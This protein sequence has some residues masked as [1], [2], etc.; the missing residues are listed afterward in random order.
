MA[1][2]Q[3][4]RLHLHGQLESVRAAPN[5]FLFIGVK[6][7]Q[8][9]KSCPHSRGG[10]AHQGA[11]GILGDVLGFCLPCRYQYPHVPYI[12]HFLSKVMGIGSGPMQ[13]KKKKAISCQCNERSMYKVEKNGLL[14]I[15][16][17]DEEG[18]FMGSFKK[19]YLN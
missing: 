15:N 11:G 4:S 17:K 18:T 5:L 2:P 10:Y 8:T 6:S 9:H 19:R 16:V 14:C 12:T 1:L 13:E 7:Y 3:H